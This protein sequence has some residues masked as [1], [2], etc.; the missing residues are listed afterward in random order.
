MC[1]I[2]ALPRNHTYDEKEFESTAHPE[3]NDREWRDSWEEDE[4]AKI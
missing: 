1:I 3:Y 4:N 2:A